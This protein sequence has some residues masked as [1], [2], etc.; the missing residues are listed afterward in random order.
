M[1]KIVVSEF[2]T[3]DGVV[4]DPGGAEGTKNGGWSFYLAAKTRASISSRN[5]F[6]ADALLLG[7]M[8]YQGFAAA[9]PTMEGTG[10]LWREDEQPAQIRRFNDPLRHDLECH[11]DQGRYWRQNYPS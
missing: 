8:T 3:L 11:P 2:I 10:R 5:Y 4:E 6:A 9:W 7:R 1:R